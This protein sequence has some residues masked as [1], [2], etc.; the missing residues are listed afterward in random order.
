M[1]MSEPEMYRM[2]RAFFWRAESS[3]AE[4]RFKYAALPA[5]AVQKIINVSVHKDS[6]ITEDEVS[7]SLRTLLAEGYRWIRT[8]GDYAIFEL[9]TKE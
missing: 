3:R 6:Y 2:A 7:F 1:P 5:L 8:D 9:E 4:R